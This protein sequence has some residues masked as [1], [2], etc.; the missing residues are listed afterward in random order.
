MNRMLYKLVQWRNAR[1]YLVSTHDR[2]LSW[3]RKGMLM[4]QFVSDMR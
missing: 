3:K 1:T 2:E 4:V